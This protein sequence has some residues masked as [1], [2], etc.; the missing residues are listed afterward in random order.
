MKKRVVITSLMLVTLGII[1]AFSTREKRVEEYLFDEWDPITP[2]TLYPHWNYDENEFNS[3]GYAFMSRAKGDPQKRALL[4]SGEILE[5]YLDLDISASGIIRVR[6]GAISAP[7]NSLSDHF[8]DPRLPPNYNLA[9]IFEESGTRISKKIRI[10]GTNADFLDIEN[11]GATPVNISGAIKLVG[12]LP[13]TSYPFLGPGTL[14]C[15]IGF[16]L[17]FYGVLA[18]PKRGII[19]RKIR[20]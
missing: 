14:I 2:S 20:M 17:L 12:K 8:N 19:G 15:L 5:L 1:L 16:F 9:A 11:E 7:N 6:V 18:K 10:D 13:T 4:E 3:T